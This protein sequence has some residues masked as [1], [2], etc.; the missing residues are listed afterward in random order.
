MR[1]RADGA[2]DPAAP[3]GESMHVML[4]MSMVLGIIIGMTLLVLAC[5]ARILWLT[6]W[7]VGL[8]LF[9]SGY[10]LAESFGWMQ[11]AELRD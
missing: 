7:S 10:L 5:R 4:T 6:V 9:A 11:L 3:Y 1:Y 8:V 2:P